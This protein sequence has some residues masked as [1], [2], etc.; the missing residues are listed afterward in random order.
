MRDTGAP[1]KAR[2]SGIDVGCIPNPDRLGYE[3][4][5]GRRAAIRPAPPSSGPSDSLRRTGRPDTKPDR[6]TGSDL[7]QEDVRHERMARRREA[8]SSVSAHPRMNHPTFVER[9]FDHAVCELERIEVRPVRSA[10]REGAPFGR[11]CETSIENVRA[12]PSNGAKPRC[13]MRRLRHIRQVKRARPGR[14]RGRGGTRAGRRD[15]VPS[16]HCVSFTG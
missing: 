14:S 15:L 8:F 10:F 6:T 9:S 16:R 1:T 12:G 13:T 4:L 7:Q 5:D 11:F 3:Y 2:R